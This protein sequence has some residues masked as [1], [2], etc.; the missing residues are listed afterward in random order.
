MSTTSAAYKPP[1]PTLPPIGP[2]FF[3]PACTLIGYFEVT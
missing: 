1:P 3:P 2:N